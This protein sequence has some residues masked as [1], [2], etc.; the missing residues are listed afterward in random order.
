M[1]AKPWLLLVALILLIAD[2]VISYI[3]RGLGVGIVA[4]ST[5]NVAARSRRIAGITV[6]LVASLTV[7]ASPT[8]AQTTNTVK[9]HILPGPRGTIRPARNI[10]NAACLCAHE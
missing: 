6:L 9:T 2:L 10:G 3:L 4:T 1:D 8:F 7:F 5:P